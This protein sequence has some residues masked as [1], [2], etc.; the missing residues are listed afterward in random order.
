LSTGEFIPIKY[1]LGRV[2]KFGLPRITLQTKYFHWYA[3]WKPIT[4][5]DPGFYWRDLDTVKQWRSENRQFVQLSW[6][7]GVGEI[8]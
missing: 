6:R 3:G 5:D 7:W 1:Q 8:S 4:L 2:V